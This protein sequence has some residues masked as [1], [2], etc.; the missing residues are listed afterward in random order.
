MDTKFKIVESEWLN[1]D[2]FL[3]TIE[4]ERIAKKSRPGQMVHIKCGEGTEAFLRRPISICQV[5]REKGT[6]NLG[7]QV[8]G[9]GTKILSRLKQGDDIDILGP[10]GHGFTLYPRH[11]KIIAVGGGIGIFPLLQLLNDHPAVDKKAIL[12]FRTRSL[13]ILEDEFRESCN[14][15]LIATD[16]GSYGEKGLVT[17]LLKVEIEKEQP[18]M[19]FLC[20]PT[21][22]MKAGV[23]LLKKYNVPCEVSMEQHMGCGIGACLTCV[24]KVKKDDDWQY[25]QVCKS[26]PVFSGEEIIFD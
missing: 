16:D 7:I 26:G 1:S 6:F 22:M 23:E 13:V 8:R 17:E 10:M 2:T 3:L 5:D 9:K 18:D 4:S 15:L 11:K 21:V 19:V 14:G 25:I 24:C 20:G 12:G